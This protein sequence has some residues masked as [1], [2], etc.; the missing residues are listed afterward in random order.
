MQSMRFG[1]QSHNFRSAITMESRSRL[2]SPGVRA[3]SV[4]GP[5]GSRSGSVRDL[6]GIRSE[7]VRGPRGI[8]SGSVRDLFEGRTGSMQGPCGVRLGSV[9]VRGSVRDPYGVRSGSVR[10]PFGVRSESVWD[11]FGARNKKRQSTIAANLP[12]EAV[13][14]QGKLRKA[15]K[16]LANTEGN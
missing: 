5:F 16:K 1:R 4:R 15:L 12:R 13:K 6:F 2:A 10:R 14:F 3:G 8:C 9:R 11:P 7:S